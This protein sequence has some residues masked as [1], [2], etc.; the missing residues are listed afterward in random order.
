MTKFYY[1]GKGYI[2]INQI[3]NSIS[4]APYKRSAEEKITPED[5]A[6]YREAIKGL[7]PQRIT[8]KFAQKRL[9]ALERINITKDNC[10]DKTAVIA[11]I[12]NA[13]SDDI[14]YSGLEFLVPSL[15][16]DAEVMLNVI[17]KFKSIEYLRLIW[18]KF[19]PAKLKQNKDFVLAVIKYCP[20]MFSVL[21]ATCSRFVKDSD[22]A[23]EAITRE[24]TLAKFIPLTLL[25]NDEICLRLVSKNGLAL[26]KIYNQ[27]EEILFAAVK[28]NGHA[29]RYV[30]R[31]NKMNPALLIE[32]LKSRKEAWEFVPNSYKVDKDFALLVVDNI[33]CEILPLMK[34][35]YTKNKIDIKKCWN[36]D[37]D[38]G[39]HALLKSSRAYNYLSNEL[40]SNP[41]ILTA[42]EKAK[43]REEE[44]E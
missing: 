18:K 25:Q 5:E 12:K 30:E 39:L 20:Q 31:E 16:L 23:I 4:S 24:P 1:E 38:V 29:L 44:S 3:V 42:Y 19:V 22:I 10:Q 26:G 43:A 17:Y 11:A 33:D 8:Q 40:Q 13:S 36:D 6:I 37:L 9:D 35:T 28:Q 41:K 27:K 2:D 14:Y 21:Y 7:P 34:Y 15:R 32:A